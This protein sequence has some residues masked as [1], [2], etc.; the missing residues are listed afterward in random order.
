MILEV[1]SDGLGTLSFGFSQFR[2][3][4]SRLMCG[5]DLSTPHEFPNGCFHRNI[6]IVR[7]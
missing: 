4:G 5:V 6:G 7:M 2:G 1:C 3:H